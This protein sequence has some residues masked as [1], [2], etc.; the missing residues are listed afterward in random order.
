MDDLQ[1]T[2]FLDGT[3][4][5]GAVGTINDFTCHGIYGFTKS[6][7]LHIFEIWAAK[8]FDVGTSVWLIQ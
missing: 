3:I 8:T 4:C 6:L 1:R 5:G 7:P 2:R